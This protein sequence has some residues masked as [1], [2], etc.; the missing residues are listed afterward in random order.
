MQNITQPGYL[1]VSDLIMVLDRN[2]VETLKGLSAG[3]VTGSLEICVTYPIKYIKT[4]MQLEEK[5]GRAKK[6][7]GILDCAKQTVKKNGF[8]GLYR[9]LNI[10]FYGPKAAIRFGA[11]ETLK[12]KFVNEKGIL[13][14]TDRF[15]CGLCAGAVEAA[16]VNTP[17]ET[18]ECKLIHDQRTEK[19]RFRGFVHGA[20][21][22]YREEGFKGIY[23]GL[24]PSVIKQSSNQGIRFFVMETLKNYYRGG[25]PNV[26]V[27]KLVVG[28]F[29]AF[30]GFCSVMGNNPVDVVKTRMQSLDHAKYKNMFD[31]FIKIWKNEG[32]FSFYRGV[33][34]RLSRVCLEVALTFMIYDALQELIKNF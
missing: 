26:P 17:L 4:Q 12:A 23:N 31:C 29:G 16:V 8:L 1:Y 27:P 20:V 15:F 25:D 6:Y 10:F 18:V 21:T 30:A 14:P 24:Y 2:T 32:F 9:G 28:L 11:F 5:F 33:T 19:P 7:S 22:I 34:P 3:A 13:S